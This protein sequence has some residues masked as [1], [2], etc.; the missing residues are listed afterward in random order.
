MS[1]ITP[2]RLGL[3]NGTGADD[4]LFLKQ[5]SGEVLTAFE[6]LNVMMD[7]HYVRTISSGKSAQFPAIGTA[8][9]YYHVP[10]NELEGQ[11]ILH[12]ERVLTIDD[13][14]VAPVFIPQ[15][16]EAK[17]HYDVRGEYTRQCGAALATTADKNILQTAVLAARDSATITGG[18][19]GSIVKGGT[20]LPANTNGALVEALYQAAQILDEKN[21]PEFDRFAIFRPAQYYK[22]VL[23]NKTINR[24]FTSG[25]GDIAQGKVYQVAGIE[26]VKSNHVPSTNITAPSGT[27]N[28]PSGVTPNIGPRPLNKY[29]GDFSDTVGIVMNRSA[30]GTV[31]LMDLTVEGEYQIN[32]QG[33]LIVAKYAMGHG[34]LRPECAVELSK[35]TATP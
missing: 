19:G 20:D 16:D 5:F 15:I 1:N 9:A 25:N 6:E 10:G 14:L 22:L 26:I 7:R 35:A 2:S 23:D 24:D 34:I 27:A 4:E 13:L 17:N 29:A 30:V 31:K 11:A 32:R 28:V 21:V 33:T 3:K 12:G 18:Y 8:S